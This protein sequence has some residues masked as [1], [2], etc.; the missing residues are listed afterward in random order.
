MAYFYQMR[1][2]RL[3]LLSLLL[4]GNGGAQI[5]VPALIGYYHNWSSVN[6]PYIPLNQVDPRYNVIDVAFALPMSGT[7]Y[8]M[9][10]VPDRGTVAGFISQ[11]QA[12]QATGKKI[13]LSVGGATAPII[14]SNTVER[15]TF[16]TS[17]TRIL[18]YYHFDGMDIDLEGNSLILSGGSIA[19]PVDA[20]L[21][22]MKE[23]I[24]GIMQQYRLATGRKLLLTFA[25]ET[26]FVQG[27]QSSFGGYW[28]AYLPLLD[29]LRDSID[30]LHV[31]LYNS[32]SMY[33]INGQ[34]Y[35]QGTADFIVAMTEAVIQGFQT[36]GGFFAGFPPEKVAVGLPSCARA[37]GSGFTAPSA[38]A[39]AMHYLLGKGPRPGTYTLANG[40]GY[41]KLAGMMT[42]SINWD[43]KASSGPVYA[44]ADNFASVYPTP[45]AQEA[46]LP[47]ADTEP[48]LFP[49][50]NQGNF[51]LRIPTAMV[52]AA[53]F[54]L[55]DSAGRML[56][57]TVLQGASEFNL[58]TP[59]LPPG[60]YI[61]KVDDFAGQMFVQ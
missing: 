41:P 45:V 39:A 11:M 14:L 50:P 25:P 2:L 16:I 46:V 13:I 5:P 55:Y 26:A 22:R 31:Q 33:G 12:L 56:N 58:S 21:L 60:I 10:F 34:V 4:W 19:N 18:L 6:V 1:F 52:T 8:R 24:Q 40:N 20:P 36:R 59:G 15:D 29:A 57:E 54:R 47:D 3:L 48:V 35:K 53:V 7:D 27:G 44:Y 28:G 43:A 49:N 32:G 51:T 17:M 9:K 37:A 61:W 38:V 23:A 30:L 42:W